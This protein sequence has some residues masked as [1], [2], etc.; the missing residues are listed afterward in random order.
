MGVLVPMD[1]PILSPVIKKAINNGRYEHQEA[2]ELGRIFESGERV[3]ELGVGIGFV[4][5]I[6]LKNK[7]VEDYIGVEANLELIPWIRKL[8]DL[9]GVDAKVL[10]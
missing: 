3:L 9:N 2:K 10:R 4:S 8:F 6:I 1:M 5:T 7:R